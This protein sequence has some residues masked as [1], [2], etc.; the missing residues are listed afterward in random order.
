MYTRG[1]AVRAAPAI[2]LATLLAMPLSLP[3]EPAEGPPGLVVWFESPT[4]KVKSLDPAPSSTAVWDGSTIRL[5]AARGEHE[6]FQAVFT[7]SDDL[8]CGVSLLPVAGPIILPT[9]S[10]EFYRVDFP[11]LN[12]TD[13][14]DPLLR[15]PNPVSMTLA[16]AGTNN[17]ILVDIFVPPYA[18]AGQYH[19]S[20]IVDTSEGNITTPLELTVWDITLPEKNTLQTW[21][22]D[23][24]STWAYYYNFTPWSA[25]HQELMKNVY[26]QYK[27]FRISPGNVALG[28]V[29]RY[30]MSVTNGMV[31]ID[32][33]GTD[34][35]LEYCLDEL[36]FTSFRFPLTGYSPRREDMDTSTGHP[37]SIY[38]WGDPPYDMNPLYADHIGQYIKLVADHYRQKGWLDKAYVYVTDEPIAFN[39]NVTSYWQHP[40]YHVV[41]QFYNLT[42][43]NAPD[44][45][46]ANTVQF[47]PELFNYT[48]VWAS[49]GGYYHE[50]DAQDRIAAGQS[51]WWYNVDAGIDSDGVMGRA[52]YWDTFSRGVQGVLYWGTNYWDYYT[53][54]S[55]PW[56]G[57]TQ[58]GDGYLFYPGNKVGI[59]DD[60]CP[61]LRLFLARDGIEDFEL[62]NL[63][64]DKYGYEAARAVAE[65]VAAGSSFAGARYRSV[66]AK[67]IYEIREWLAGQLTRQ[68]ANLAWTD[69]FLDAGN[70]SDS[71][72]LVPDTA[73]EGSYSLAPANPPMM[74]DNL[75][76]LG[77]WRPNNQPHIFSSVA[78]DNSIKTE[79]SG[80]LRIDFWRD[81]DPGE[82]GG[83]DNMRNGRV[84]TD[85]LA[86]TDWSGCD[87]LE[88]DVRSVDHPAGNLNIL[89]GDA[90]GTVVSSNLHRYARYT[91]GPGENWT[92]FVIDISGSSRSSIQYIEPI[93]YNYF[94]EVPFKHYTYWLDNITVRRSGVHPTGVL[95]SKPIDLGSVGKFDSIEYI[96]PWDLPG[97]DYLPFETRSS[98][99]SINWSAWTEAT[100]DGKFRSVMNS[101]AA[102]YV[103]YRTPLFALGLLSPGLSEVRIVYGPLVET[104]LFVENMTFDPPVPNDNRT[105]NITVTV[106]NNGDLDVLGAYVEFT[107]SG[108]APANDFANIS[109]DLF[110]RSSISLTV[111]SSLAARPDAVHC[112]AFVKFPS[113]QFTDPEINNNSALG[114]VLINDYPSP[115]IDA[116]ATALVGEG[117]VFNASGSGDWQG[118]DR[119]IWSFPDQ[120]LTGPAVSRSFAS[121]GDVAYHL[122]VIDIHGA[123]SRLDG[124][125]A[126]YNHTPVP[127]FVITPE[128]GTVLTRFTFISTAIDPDR[129]VVNT[130]WLFG[131]GLAS[132]GRVVNHTFADDRGY[133]VDCTIDYFENG[134]LYRATA[135]RILK[136]EN[137]PPVARFTATNATAG[138]REPLG[139]DASASSDPDDELSESGFLWLFGDGANATG[140]MA[141]HSYTR[142]GVYNVT[143]AVTD[144]DGAIS[145]FAAMVQIINQFPVAD[146]SLPINVTC[147]RSFT[148]DASKSS[149]PDGSL[150]GYRWE[151][152][153]G[154]CATGAV[155]S[156]S[157]ALPGVRAVT[158]VVTDDD[159][160]TGRLVRTIRA[161]PEPGPTRPR[162]ADTASV[163][164]HPA[165]YVAVGLIVAFIVL[166]IASRARPRPKETSRW[167]MAR[168]ATG[169][170]EPAS[171]RGPPPGLPPAAVVI[172]EPP[173]AA[174]PPAAPV[175]PPP[176]ARAPLAPAP[177]PFAGVPAP[178]GGPPAPLRQPPRIVRAIPPPPPR[179]V[180]AIPAPADAALIDLESARP[181]KTIELSSPQK[182]PGR[183]LL[184]AEEPWRLGAGP[185]VKGHLETRP[186]QQKEPVRPAEPPE[187]EADPTLPSNPW[188]ERRK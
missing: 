112:D 27:K 4:V 160:A 86:I 73:W 8:T 142:A 37:D 28:Q 165:V 94:L 119:Y 152:D 188:A 64:G 54:G 47:V 134:T 109:V 55:D 20:L 48:D 11:G 172:S 72:Y 118:I 30:N 36:N 92:H 79:G 177:A 180:R 52:L 15:Y 104:D 108:S 170:G 78:I 183:A 145:T 138:K 129:V 9:G 175:A 1:N 113:G 146:F 44:L 40:D 6:A 22:D 81:D 74:V 126:V 53:V 88:M 140:R 75:D 132:F 16:T 179:V 68:T 69:T 161:D 71:T 167:S 101:P 98:A 58:N 66:E 35:W 65:S 153:D 46:F 3:S 144:D 181:S 173:G 185:P 42:K 19:S 124:T 178:Q 111:N 43:A 67:T 56:N 50:L 127:S 184:A 99:D 25:E 123:G 32:F 158:L 41:Q 168:A 7:F 164:I 39:D 163:I 128:S 120:E 115:S 137:L 114:W 100:P 13:W 59:T 156:H 117:V 171:A 187:E 63:Y 107:W 77:G 26:A 82:L 38:F 106:G 131:D 34:P 166:F 61:S 159:G 96:T 174:P 51:A 103:Q 162:P 182:G 133:T 83:Y 91:G 87:L 136:I 31:S 176:P 70:V 157:F 29:G 147:N 122:T 2:L 151:F 18:P 17:I 121:A 186:A 12:N 84:V 76:A 169:P 45:K 60:V 93:V 89:V 5:S 49:P 33:S 135:S 97:G 110:A 125:I 62:L 21:F 80:S 57:S 95:L 10:T 149:D 155:V 116:P 139:F 105:F 102:R 23:S 141:S 130:T 154:T 14:P 90:G 150:V 85:T 24:P 148:L 143:L